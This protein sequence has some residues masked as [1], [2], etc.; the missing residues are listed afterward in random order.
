MKHALKTVPIILILLLAVSCGERKSGVSSDVLYSIVSTLPPVGVFEHLDLHEETATGY[1]SA[2]YIGLLEVDFS[3]PENPV[4]TDTIENNYLGRVWSAHISEVS[5]YG[6]IETGDSYYAAKAIRAFLLDSIQTSGSSILAIG[7]P[8]VNQF[9]VQEFSRDSAGTVLTDSLYLYILARDE[10]PMFQRHRYIHTG[11]YWDGPT[12]LTYNANEPYDFVFDDEY[13]YL[14][15]DERGMA[16][17]DK[18]N[19]LAVIGE[20][21]TEG[22]CRG[23][24]V[25]DDYC[26]LADRHWGLQVIDVSDPANPVRA[27]N[28]KYEGADDCVKVKVLNDRAVVLDQYDGIFAVDIADPANPRT[29]FNVDTIT[30]IDIVVTEEYIY[31]IDEDAGLVVISW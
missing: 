2:D 4:I 28:L 14:A 26:Y 3:D 15:I 24:A 29:I 6:Y 9:E 17:L 25:Q 20:F 31:V 30:P 21:D 8:P 22:Y 7:S 18:A 1:I 10:S 27:A 12:T 5:G 19:N 23:I 16:I 13:V 11:L